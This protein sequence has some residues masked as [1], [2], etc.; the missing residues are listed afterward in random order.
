MLWVDF[1]P[2]QTEQAPKQRDESLLLHI[3]NQQ[4]F[5]CLCTQAVSVKQALG[6]KL[7]S[8][9]NQKKKNNV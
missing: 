6:S 4:S 7:Q 5:L 2:F 9:L 8:N 3:Q 1:L